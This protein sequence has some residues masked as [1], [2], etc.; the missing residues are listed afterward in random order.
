MTRDEAK[1]LLPVIQ[2]Y[3]DGKDVQAQRS[4]GK[5]IDIPA[6]DG[7]MFNPG[8]EYRIKRE[9]FECWFVLNSSGV[10]AGWYESEEEAKIRI[11]TGASPPYTIHHMREVIE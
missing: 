1:K 10:S 8:L 2:A 5:W 6:R 11:C 3:A 4:D 7:P 9:P